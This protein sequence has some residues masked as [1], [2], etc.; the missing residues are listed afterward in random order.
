MRAAFARRY[1]AMTQRMEDAWLDAVRAEVLASATGTVVE[2]GAGTGKNLRHYP[3]TVDRVVLTEPGPAMRD[4]LRRR[5]SASALD[6]DVEIVDATADRIPVPDASADTVVATLVL[7]SVPSLPAVATELR[8]ILRP[9][10]RILLVE[11]VV[12]ASGWERRWQRRLDGVWNWIEGSCHLDHDT[13]AALADA[14]FDVSALERRRPRGQPPLF[15][16][17]VVGA[18]VGAVA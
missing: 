9:G 8:R 7:C 18:V 5:V 12:A 14:G 2:L 15:R 10:G 3:T 4:Q 1:D 17:V 11:H 6:V 13:P 16:D